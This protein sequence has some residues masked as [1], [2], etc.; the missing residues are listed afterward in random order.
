M[1][2]RNVRP[3]IILVG[4]IVGLLWAALSASPAWADEK[5]HV[6]E[7]IE[8]AT[9]AAKAGRAGD[10]AMLVEHAD[11]ALRYAKEAQKLMPDAHLDEAIDEL[12]AAVFQ[13]RA[14]NAD[15]GVQHVENALEH[16]SEV[17]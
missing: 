17:K 2:T 14:G 12:E 16:L 5:E 13:G 7:A 4:L 15:A 1:K 9:E 10:T 3:G 6:G 8:H 11:G